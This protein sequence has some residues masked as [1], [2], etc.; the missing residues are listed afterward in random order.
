MHKA[1]LR[2]RL[3]YAFD[4][5]MA[6]G[7]ATLT[8]ALA[9]LTAIFVFAT[10]F[11]ADELHL[12]P[13]P[14][15]G[16]APDFWELSWGHLIRAFEPS[17][18][19]DDSGGYRVVTVIVALGGIFVLSSFISLL[20]NGLDERL[21]ELRRGRSLVVERG[22][23]VILGWSPQVIPIVQ[24]LCEANRNQGKS[25][26]VILG[27]ADKAEMD[28]ELRTKVKDRGRTR[29]VTRT[30]SPMDLDDLQ[31]TNPN[32]AK[33]F[34]LLAPEEGD[35]DTQVLKALLALTNSPTRRQ[36]P[37]HIV[38]VMRDAQNLEVARLVGKKEAQ[39]LL[40]DDVLARITVQTT[41]QSGLSVV[42]TEL[43]NF[44][45]DEIYLMPCGALAGK[46][47]AEA[48]FCCPDVTLLGIRSK[49][50]GTRLLPPLDTTLDA[51]DD[52][53]CVC[54]DD[55]P[56]RIVP[57]AAPDRSLIVP[58]E[59][60]APKPERTL[61][62]GWNQR[63]PIIVRTFDEYA[64]VGSQ[65]VIVSPHDLAAEVAELAADLKRVKLSAQRG[66]PTARAVLLEMK[67]ESFDQVITLS[68]GA[69]ED[70]QTAD[71]K[72][73]ATLLHLRD[74]SD[75]QAARFSIVSE[76]R[77]PRNRDLAEATRADD[78]IISD[79]LVGL[80]LSQLAED[81][82]LLSV[83]ED[84]LDADGSELYV[85][86]IEHYVQTGTPV[87]YWT[88]A[89]AAIDRGE[90]ALGYRLIKARNERPS[91]GVVLNPKDKAEKVTFA[92]GDR[93]VVLAM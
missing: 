33:A 42:Y 7:T 39:L 52:L 34:V 49:K 45:G 66:D 65:I 47:L 84:L 35:P 57:P 89:Q 53:I 64:A 71:A 15:G 1:T 61:I 90:L 38:A 60:R 55:N 29:V 67:P 9:T 73:L 11:I 22:H 26:V 28:E 81:R 72:T 20:T 8:L 87:D 50:G 18:I 10:A 25:C 93:I 41:R 48:V 5:L 36:A 44:D 12:A 92:P 13:A 69:I 46:T 30:G 4:N 2:Q 54:E 68:D 82:R 43:F 58:H 31:L 19:G 6:R 83:F 14:E 3:S 32:E 77:D 27:E 40:V 74:I 16:E 85:K 24:E 79:R 56:L 86:P 59:E 51:S 37:Y 91:Y 17:G 88:L 80:M 75:K 70:T 21:E 63:G 78:F 62:F 76:M 23:T